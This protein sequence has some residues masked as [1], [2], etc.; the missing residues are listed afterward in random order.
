MT[1]ATPYSFSPP[2][3]RR[4]YRL[5]ER[6]PIPADQIM[7]RTDGRRS[8][9]RW[10]I[11]NG[12]VGGVPFCGRIDSL[13]I[14]TDQR[15]YDEVRGQMICGHCWGRFS[16]QPMPHDYE[17][18]DCGYDTAC[19]IW[20]RGFGGDGYG[21]R[22]VPD[23]PRVVAVHRAAYEAAHGDIPGG[24]VVHHRCE[25]P[26]CM[27]PDHLEAMSRADHCRLHRPGDHRVYG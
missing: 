5:M 10:H 25:Q 14:T 17:E 8:R 23:G 6:R 2:R 11:L 7:G 19:L 22:C 13:A 3:R 18:R 9:K 15:T 12:G 24:F 20:V 4:G 1:D 26:L 27:N 16:W 21:Q